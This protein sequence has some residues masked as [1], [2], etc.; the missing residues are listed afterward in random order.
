MDFSLT[1]LFV[2]PSG[3]LAPANSNRA[4]LTPMQFGIFNSRY[5]AVNNATDA[6][7][8]PYIQ[9]CMGRVE[10]VPGLGDKYSDKVSDKSLIE[11]YSVRGSHKPKNQITYIGW[12]GID[13]TKTISA[14]CDEEY[15]VTLRLFSNGISM[16][17]A[18]GLTKSVNVLTPCCDEC[19]SGDCTSADPKWLATELSRKINEEAWLSKYVVATPIYSCDPEI[20]ETQVATVN[21]AVT[22]IDD[23]SEQ[24][25]AAIQAQYPGKVISVKQRVGLYTTYVFTQLGTD[26]APASAVTTQ[27]IALALCDVCPSGFTLVNAKDRYLIETPLDGSENLVGSTNQQTFADAVKATYA[28]PKLFNGATAVDPTTNQITITSHGL[29]ANQAVTYSNGG[30]TTIVG[31]TN[32]ATYYVKTVIDAN[33]ITLSA[34]RGGTVVDITADGVGASHSLTFDSTAKFLS[35]DGGSAKILITL[36][37]NYNDLVAVAADILTKLDVTE[38]TCNPPTGSTTAWVADSVGYMT[39]RTMRITVSNDCSGDLATIQAEYPNYTVT[40]VTTA[41]CNS[42]YQIVQNSTSVQEDCGFAISPKFVDIQPFRGIEWTQYGGGPIDPAPDCLVGIKIEGKTLDVFGN[43]CDITAW[44]HEFDRLRFDAFAY[45][46]PFTSQ[47]YP[48]VFNRCDFWPITKTQNANYATGSGKELKAMELR[49][50]SYQT[51]HKHIFRNNDYNGAFFQYT[52]ESKF[53]DLFYVQ[54]K[55]PDMNTWDSATRQDET[56]IIAVPEGSGA[57]LEAFLTGYFGA[58]SFNGGVL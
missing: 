24:A 35:N 25:M 55:S 12:D 58:P 37:V 36:D 23:G 26:S 52:D 54:F 56:V 16:A 7:K 41:N 27:P 53:Y 50:Y 38:A 3:D 9:F 20:T 57:Q 5:K 6:A 18:N 31:L 45:K 2:L 8:S 34:T 30:G 15:S 21:Y 32:G 22:V 11:W 33:N 29:V 17:F 13:A 48:G 14:G 10:K 19:T 44:P 40:L 4:D 42:Q 51:T 49:Y 39:Q 47:D 28:A 43:S 1:T 46:A